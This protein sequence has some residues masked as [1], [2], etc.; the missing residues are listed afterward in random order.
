MAQRQHGTSRSY[1]IDRLR[2]EGLADLVAAIESGRVS[3]YAV[4]C[5][6]G[7]VTRHAT[8]GTGSTNQSKRRRYQLRILLRESRSDGSRR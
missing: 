4:G 6:L 5:E 2:R 7:W 3:A 8:L 1:L